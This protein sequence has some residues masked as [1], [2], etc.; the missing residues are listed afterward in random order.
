M[1]G[2]YSNFSNVGKCSTKFS[3]KY[4]FR[5]R[6]MLDKIFKQ[7]NFR[8]R[9]MLDKIS[10]QTKVAQ[11]I[12]IRPESDHC[13]LSLF[14]LMTCSLMFWGLVDVG[15]HESI[16]NSFTSNEGGLGTYFNAGI[17]GFDLPPSPFEQCS[18]TAI[19]VH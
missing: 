15:V 10:K 4:I 6:Q 12:F 11:H 14:S 17:H 9:Q 7:I 5:R 19:S 16:G 3:S 13:A 18:K 8:C 2:S 1:A